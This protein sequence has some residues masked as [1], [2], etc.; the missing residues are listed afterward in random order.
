MGFYTEDSIPHLTTK[1]LNKYT[2]FTID[3]SLV[4]TAFFADFGPLDLGLTYKFCNQLHDHLT[5][6]Q[7]DNKI[8]LF[9]CSKHPHQRSIGAVLLCSYLVRTIIVLKLLYV[10]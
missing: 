4:Y 2:L 10:Y 5:K 6:A 9:S 8:V 1:E 3:P 7:R